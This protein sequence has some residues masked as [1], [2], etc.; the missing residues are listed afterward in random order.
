MRE[1]QISYLVLWIASAALAAKLNCPEAHFWNGTSCNRCSRCPVGQGVKTNCSESKDTICQDCWLGF[2]YSNSTGM[3]ACKGC[4]QDSNCLPGNS[5]VIQKCTVTSPRVCDG[6]EEG[7]Y[8][9]HFAREEDGGCMKCSPSCSENEIETQSCNTKHDRVCSKRPSTTEKTSTKRPSTTEKT[10]TKRSSTTEKTSTK[11]PTTLRNSSATREVSTLS[12]SPVN[13]SGQ[14]DGKGSEPEKIKETDQPLHKKSWLWAVIAAGGVIIA[15]PVVVGTAVK[16]RQPRPHVDN[17]P[18]R[19]RLIRRRQPQPRGLD[20]TIRSIEVDGRSF[21][22]ERL[23]DKDSQDYWFFLRVAEKLGIYQECSHF[24]SSRNPT[25]AFLKLYSEREG[26]TVRALVGALR[27][28]ELTLFASEIEMK[29]ASVQ[30]T[31]EFR[32]AEMDERMV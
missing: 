2:D 25:E 11:R 10:S 7:F 1:A 14:G 20:Q 15:L 22:A 30:E 21:I 9:N 4:D 3:E 13:V 27:E 31:E 24:T 18:S 29:F 26:S 23:N 32:A 28:C 8:L 5:K 19:I 16:Y 12:P 17:N 6:C